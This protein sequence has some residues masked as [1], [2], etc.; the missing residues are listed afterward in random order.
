MMMWMDQ[1]GLVNSMGER[2]RALKNE[3]YRVEIDGV[4]ATDYCD[5]HF[6]EATVN[7]TISK[8]ILQ[9]QVIEEELK[10]EMAAAE[11]IP[12]ES[13]RVVVVSQPPKLTVLIKKKD[14]QEL[15]V[16]GE[17]DDTRSV[18]GLG[19]IKRQKVEATQKTAATQAT[20][21]SIFE[22]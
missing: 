17:G 7:I 13:K 22:P 5:S 10:R 12:E 8:N 9:S 2:L 3:T 21:T 18:S 14:L 15:S 11:V 16:K 1:L 4:E 6:A 20:A 19:S